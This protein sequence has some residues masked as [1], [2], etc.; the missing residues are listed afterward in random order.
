MLR[1]IYDVDRSRFTFAFMN[2]R[3]LADTMGTLGWNDKAQIDR[4]IAENRREIASRGLKRRPSIVQEEN[5]F[6]SN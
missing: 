5:P 2:A 3:E 4:W 1:A 6:R